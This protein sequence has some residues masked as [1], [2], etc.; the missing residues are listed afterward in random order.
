MRGTFPSIAFREGVLAADG[1]MSLLPEPQFAVAAD[2]DEHLPEK[3]QGPVEVRRHHET[4]LSG[5]VIFP[6]TPAQRNGL[7][8]L[9][10]LKFGRGA[11]PAIMGRIRL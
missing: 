10:L 5:T 2:T 3:F 8:D 1:G 9:R 7:E 6:V 11:S 4:S